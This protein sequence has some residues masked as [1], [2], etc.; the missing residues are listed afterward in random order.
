MNQKRD[1]YQRVK[2]HA[3][4][5]TLLILFIAGLVKLIRAELGL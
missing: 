5:L 1:L 3:W 4:Q 2:Y